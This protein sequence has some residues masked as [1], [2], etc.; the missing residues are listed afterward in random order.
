[1][2]LFGLIHLAVG[3]GLTYYTISLLFNKT[4]IW[5]NR[6]DLIIKH[7]PLPSFKAGMNHVNPRELEQLYVKEK[8]SKSKNGTSRSYSLRGKFRDGTDKVVI[9]Q[10]VLH[11]AQMAMQLEEEIE[12]FLG[13]TD[14]HVEDEYKDTK[15]AYMNMAASSK[16]RNLNRPINPTQLSLR[17]LKKG[18][19]LN[20]Q[21][22]GWEVVY[23]TQYDW[24]AEESDR[25]LQL[26]GSSGKDTLLYL[27]S[28]MATITPWTEERLAT[29]EMIGEDFQIKKRD[30]EIVQ[31]AWN[32]EVYKLSSIHRGKAFMGERMNDGKS[33]Q[34]RF[35]LTNDRQKYLRMLHIDEAGT[36]AYAGRKHRSNDFTDILPNN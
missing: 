24:Q 36:Y 7:H 19:V 14:Y 1:M 23:E 11:N 15:Y 34:Q 33:C 30:D 35:Y 32:A 25:Q 5:V 29:H 16:P 20:F 9:S 3:I 10:Y 17:D 18:Y 13:I 12:S 4:D 2:G 28:D 8:I 22:H 26:S 21:D 6:D 31:I 27:Q